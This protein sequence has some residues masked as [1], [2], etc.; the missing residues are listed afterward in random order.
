MYPRHVALCLGLAIV[1]VASLWGYRMHGK[2]QVQATRIEALEGDLAAAAATLETLQAQAH[3]E[4]V[5][6][7]QRDT[8]RK[9]VKHAKEAVKHAVPTEVRPRASDAQ[10]DRL[11]V[12]AAAANAAAAS[13]VELP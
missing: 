5:Q 8:L 3:A 1:L 7:T 9:P 10:L 13:A 6:S 11:R 2:A 12:L 4:V